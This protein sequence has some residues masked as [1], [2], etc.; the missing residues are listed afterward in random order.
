MAQA[1]RLRCLRES[2]A[3]RDDRVMRIHALATS[4]ALAVAGA[5]AP[6][7][8]DI[9]FRVVSSL[10]LAPP[11]CIADVEVAREDVLLLDLGADAENANSA[12]TVLH[13]ETND[14][15]LTVTT[16]EITV[17]GVGNG[18][19]QRRGLMGVAVQPEPEVPLAVALVT[20]IA[21]DE[22]ANLQLDDDVTSTLLTPADRLRVD[23]EVVLEGAASRPVNTN[24]DDRCPPPL[25]DVDGPAFVRSE[26]FR[27]AIDLCIGCLVPQCADGEMAV[28]ADAGVCVRGQDYPSVCVPQ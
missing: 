21:R 5:C 11:T 18:A 3:M 23:V 14:E 12:I 16:A 19:A 8:D 10:A 13:Y 28:P 17:R 24:A 4:F 2:H 26:P 22:A 20:P 15:S 6:D 27:F 25:A 1:S 9:T 7:V